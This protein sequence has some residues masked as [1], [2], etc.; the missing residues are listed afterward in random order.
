MEALIVVTFIIALIN[1][2]VLGYMWDK[3]RVFCELYDTV[4]HNTITNMRTLEKKVESLEFLVK[5]SQVKK[6]S[7]LSD[8]VAP[9]KKNVKTTRK[10][11][12]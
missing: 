7:L 8:T 9:I 11:K 10:T 2:V 6:P 5:T 3:V 1:S 12:Q 4:Q